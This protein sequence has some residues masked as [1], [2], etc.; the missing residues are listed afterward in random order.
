MATPADAPPGAKGIGS[1]DLGSLLV[2]LTASGG[3]LTTLVG[4]LQAWLLRHSGSQIVVEIDGD[5][6]ELTGA[7]DDELR[8]ALEVWLARHDGGGDTAG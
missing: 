2:V 6:L 7:T 8:R 1:G 5:R 4:T 3:V